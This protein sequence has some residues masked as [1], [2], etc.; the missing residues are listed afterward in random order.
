MISKEH[1]QLCWWKM[2]IMDGSLDIFGAFFKFIND[3]MGRRLVG[4]D[5]TESG[6]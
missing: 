2:C 1:P 6:L 4:F 5:V 3:C